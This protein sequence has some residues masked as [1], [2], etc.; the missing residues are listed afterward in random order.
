MPEIKLTGN[1]VDSNDDPVAYPFSEF[2]NS[3]ESDAYFTSNDPIHPNNLAK[4]Y[5]VHPCPNLNLKKSG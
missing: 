1:I 4:R 5:S 3:L 2:F